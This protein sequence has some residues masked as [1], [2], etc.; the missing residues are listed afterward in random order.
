MFPLVEIRW[1]DSRLP[2]SQWQYLSDL[3]GLQTCVCTSVGYLVAE[4]DGAKVLAMSLAD[5]DS[6]KPQASGVVVI[7]ES[8]VIAITNLGMA[9]YGNAGTLANPRLSDSKPRHGN[10]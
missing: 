4:R 8:S 2:V 9:D 5:I 1:I 10:I 6:Q 3:M 7:P